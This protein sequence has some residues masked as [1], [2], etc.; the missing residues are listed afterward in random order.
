MCPIIC[1]FKCLQGDSGGPVQ[2]LNPQSNCIYIVLGI[3]SFGFSCGNREYPPV[4]TN[5]S[6]YIDWIESH[7]WPSMWYV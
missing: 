2:I 3:T 4:Y 5:V 6:S 7:V 1:N